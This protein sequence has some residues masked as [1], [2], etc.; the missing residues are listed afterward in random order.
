[1][2]RNRSNAFSRH[3]SPPFFREG[4]GVGLL[5][6][7]LLFTDPASAQSD[8]ITAKDFLW[9]TR[10][11]PT[12]A[13]IYS[14]VLPGAGQVY[15]RKYW[16]VPIVLGGL[17]LSYYFIDQNRTEYERYKDAYLAVIDGDSSTVD[18]FNGQYSAASLLDVS[19][20][21]RRW[22]DLSYIAFG[23]VYVLNVMDAAVD[24]HFV[25]FDLGKD[26]SMALRPDVSLAAHGALGF[27]LSVD[28]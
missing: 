28:L 8:T 12:R 4:L 2:I 23:L 3:N 16:K 27:T 25:R 13:T 10:H 7:V 18:E 26:M 6:L 11:S 22:M 14:A 24:A 19:D 9:K 1:M 17:G 20:T 5:L 15:N 21:Y